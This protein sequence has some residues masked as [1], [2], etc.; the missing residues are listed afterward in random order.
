[1]PGQEDRERGWE[2]TRGGGGE[3][4]KEGGREMRTKDTACSCLCIEHN[5]YLLIPLVEWPMTRLRC[6]G[7]GSAC[8]FASA[9]FQQG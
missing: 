9:P 4:R 1:M 5:A 2:Q 3:W 6:E 8:L 7:C